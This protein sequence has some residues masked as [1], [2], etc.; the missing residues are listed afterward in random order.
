MPSEDWLS[1]KLRDAYPI[2]ARPGK[3]RI[4]RTTA[5]EKKRYEQAL[6][7]RARPK[8]FWQDDIHAYIDNK[9]FVMARTLGDKKRLRATR[10]HH[11]L[12]T[13]QE[14]GEPGFV[15]PKLNR[16]LLGL[17]SVDITA[18]VAKDRIIFWHVN[19]SWN[20]DKAAEMY[21]ELGKALRKFWGHKRLFRVVEDGD[22]KG[23]QS[24]KGRDAKQKQKIESWTLPPRSPDWMPLDFCLWDEIESRL[25]AQRITRTETK[26]RWV[27]RLRS[28]A[29]SLPPAL[30]KACLAKIKGNIEATVE[31]R[32]RTTKA[33]LE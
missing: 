28:V 16:M 27:Q 30:I 4:S 33:L 31:S 14:G 9:K 11:H 23:F 7:W 21:E 12:R 6:V 25:L 5:H 24:G 22:T 20:G 10:V 3:R 19:P 15:L 29:M 17:P 1:R 18:A 26:A 13:P 32:G 8:A 2:R